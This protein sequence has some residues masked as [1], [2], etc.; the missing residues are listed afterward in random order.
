R[1]QYKSV[2]ANNSLRG[3]GN[4]RYFGEDVRQRLA[5]M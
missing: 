5:V 2:S 4:I 1:F 3:L